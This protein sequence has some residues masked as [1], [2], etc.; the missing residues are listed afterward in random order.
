M[1]ALILIIVLLRLFRIGSLRLMLGIVGFFTF[2]ILT[3]LLLLS[4]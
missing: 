1:N 4:W 2:V 3:F